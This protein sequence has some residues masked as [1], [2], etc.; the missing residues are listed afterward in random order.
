MVA[1]VGGLVWLGIPDVAGG[2]DVIGWRGAGGA[3]TSPMRGLRGGT[4][5]GNGGSHNRTR[6]P[7]DA[8]TWIPD[9]RFAAVA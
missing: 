1:G 5:T 7:R 8:T 2:A 3:H 4:P 6:D 9:P